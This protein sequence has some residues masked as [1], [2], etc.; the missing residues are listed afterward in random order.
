MVGCMQTLKYKDNNRISRVIN[1][2]RFQHFMRNANMSATYF[3]YKEFSYS[4]SWKRHHYISCTVLVLQARD[5]RAGGL[6]VIGSIRI[7]D[8]KSRISSVIMCS[9]SL[10]ISHPERRTI[11][12]LVASNQWSC[13][14][15]FLLRSVLASI[16]WVP[17]NCTVPILGLQERSLGSS[18]CNVYD[19]HRRSVST[20]VSNIQMKYR[21]LQSRIQAVQLGRSS[22]L[23]SYHQ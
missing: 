8:G 1:Y 20:A 7:L 5:S 17:P 12:Q 6:V 15:S 10:R 11:L 2:F 14:Q 3:H 16:L 21:L 13:Q 4:W 18:I 19:S 22:S 23:W 9:L